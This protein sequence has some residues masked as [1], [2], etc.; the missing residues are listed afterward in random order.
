MKK[1][2]LAHAIGLIALSW[3][4]VLNAQPPTTLWENTFGGYSV[5][6]G[7]SVEQFWQANFVVSGVKNG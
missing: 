4:Q 6:V 2:Y 7:Y 5:D 1:K 3:T